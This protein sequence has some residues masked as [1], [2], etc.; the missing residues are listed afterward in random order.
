MKR[1]SG[2]L[3]ACHHLAPLRDPLTHRYSACHPAPA[4]N[5]SSLSWFVAVAGASPGRKGF[6]GKKEWRNSARL[7][8]AQ[9][10]AVGRAG[11]SLWFCMHDC[12][13]CFC[14]SRLVR[15]PGDDAEDDMPD[16]SKRSTATAAG[17]TR[18]RYRRRLRGKTWLLKRRQKMMRAVTFPA[19]VKSK[20]CRGMSWSTCL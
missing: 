9:C 13:P 2:S 10:L 6:E 14:R 18:C 7:R 1:F 4:R 17:R 11:A 3:E 20:P 16:P 5:R 15:G 19:L 8:G 12:V